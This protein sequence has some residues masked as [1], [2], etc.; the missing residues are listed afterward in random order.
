MTAL[1]PD[2]T[3]GLA[4][5]KTLCDLPK[6]VI[7]LGCDLVRDLLGGP[8]KVAGA[9][10]SDQVYVWQWRNRV[11]IANRAAE[12]MERDGIARRIVPPSF[13]LPLLEAAGNVE[14]PNLQEM[15]ARLLASGVEADEHQHPMWVR[16]L[17]QMSGED[18][19]AFEF[20]CATAAA[21]AVEYA[22]DGARPFW[23]RGS[24]IASHV[25]LEALG[26]AVVG[27]R[28]RTGEAVDR[29][30]VVQ[31]LLP[32]RLGAQFRRAVMPRP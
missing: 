4:A 8:V 9:M 21:A 30:D 2:P 26:L 15:W 16:I 14:D 29:T 12:I 3:T 13:L 27:S 11:R 6:P 17:A 5:L 7:D 1:P 23:P 10:L 18:A 28:L 31:P 32:T 20:A 25:R 22:A 24:D 19:R